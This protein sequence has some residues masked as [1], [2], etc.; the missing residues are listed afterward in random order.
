MSRS[1]ILNQRTQDLH[2]YPIWIG[3]GVGLCTIASLIV[4]GILVGVCRGNSLV[5]TDQQKQIAK[6]R[7]MADKV[8][9]EHESGKDGLS[10]YARA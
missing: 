5:T 7:E 2:I 3:E 6:W 4:I 1:S 9:R 8:C 10:L